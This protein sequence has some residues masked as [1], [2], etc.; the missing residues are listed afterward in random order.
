MMPF[1]TENECK[2]LFVHPGNL[3][4]AVTCRN[5][6]ENNKKR[7]EDERKREGSCCT[8]LNKNNKPKAQKYLVSHLWTKF[9]DANIKLNHL[10]IAFAWYNF[11][12]VFS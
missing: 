10:S 5:N 1:F 7:V 8:F 11:F 12:L 6:N 4:R 3:N 9:C 2:C